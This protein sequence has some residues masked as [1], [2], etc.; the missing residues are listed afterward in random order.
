MTHTYTQTH[1]HTAHT[2]TH[3][4]MHKCTHTHTH[5]IPQS[6]S[7]VAQ[8][9]VKDNRPCLELCLKK[10]AATMEAIEV[11]QTLRHTAH[12][13]MWSLVRAS[14]GPVN[15]LLAA[16]RSYEATLNV[17]SSNK[18]LIL[19]SILISRF[20]HYQCTGQVVLVIPLCQPVAV[21]LSWALSLLVA[22]AED[23]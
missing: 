18:A 12:T 21:A 20:I 9:S 5:T 6:L 14:S 13:H 1:T 23:G 7:D 2:Q 4:H 3:T 16:V 11:S 22:V 15:N 8:S 19:H 10:L 17:N